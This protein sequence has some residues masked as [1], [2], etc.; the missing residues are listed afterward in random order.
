MGKITR[1]ARTAAAALAA[2]VTLVGVATP[3]NA[4]VTRQVSVRYED[5]E[6][7]YEVRFNGTVSHGANPLL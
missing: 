1:S 5:S 4:V 2:F 7:Y 6:G 3:A